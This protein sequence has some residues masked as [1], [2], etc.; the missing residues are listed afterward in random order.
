MRYM[1]RGAVALLLLTMLATAS[2]CAILG[3]GFAGVGLFAGLASQLGGPEQEA[4]LG[5]A[6]DFAYTPLGAQTPVRLSDHFGQP[7]VLNFWA[8]WCGPCVGEFPHFKEVHD[9]HR[10]QFTLL[11]L[12]VA[13]SMDPDGFVAANGYDWS[14]GRDTENAAQVYG[15][16]GIPL[17]LFIDR[18]G[19]IVDQHL[20]G[21]DAATFEAS[22]AKIL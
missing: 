20:G 17:T 11:S 19:R 10:G 14:F 5:F 22:L 21:I 9:A 18:N 4:Q 8:D 6:E 16:Q 13:S 15:V 12:A 7:L 1:L 2:G 3:A